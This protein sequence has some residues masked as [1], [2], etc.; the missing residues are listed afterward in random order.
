M[1]HLAW[2]EVGKIGFRQGLQRE[3]RATGT[4]REYGAVAGRLQHDLCAFG[5]FADN[6]VEHV[7]GHRRA[8]AGSC[9][10]GDRVGHLQIE[11]RRFQAER[12]AIGADEYVGENR[13]GVAPLHRTMHVAERSQQ[14]GTLHGDLHCEIRS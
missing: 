10:R 6:V 12:R 3:A 4:D 2:N 11:I 9:L 7:G 13:N 1:R 5:Q 8:A 14:L